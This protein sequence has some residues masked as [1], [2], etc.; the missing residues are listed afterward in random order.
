[1]DISVMFLGLLRDSTHSRIA[2]E[3]VYEAVQVALILSKDYLNSLE[4]QVHDG[5]VSRSSKSR[6]K[7]KGSDV[8]LETIFEQLQM[9]F[10]TLVTDIHQIM[11]N[12]KWRK[13]N[14]HKEELGK[15]D[16]TSSWPYAKRLAEIPK[17][18]LEVRKHHL[19]HTFDL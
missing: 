10:T 6:G 19:T 3:G 13:A 14:L 16:H 5:K 12:P 15:G 8:D 2:K 17:E 11:R 18:E 4:K 9:P 7:G 1:M